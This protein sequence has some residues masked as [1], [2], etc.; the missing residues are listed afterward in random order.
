[1]QR[2]QFTTEAD[3]DFASDLF[4]ADGYVV[5]ADL[6]DVRA[7]YTDAPECGIR[8]ICQEVRDCRTALEG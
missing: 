4:K 6:Y 8:R 3:R 1:M 2:I 7:L 5:K